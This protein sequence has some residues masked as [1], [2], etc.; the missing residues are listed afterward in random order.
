MLMQLGDITWV[1]EGGPLIAA[2]GVVAALVVHINHARL[3]VVAAVARSVLARVIEGRVLVAILRGAAPGLHIYHSVQAARA[4][5]LLANLLCDVSRLV[6]P[7]CSYK[8]LD[9]HQ[10]LQ[11]SN[12]IQVMQVYLCVLRRGS[13]T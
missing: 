12:D 9:G 8:K 4:L 7:K 1:V 2:P 13:G 11:A 10:A 5:A 6:A 3:A